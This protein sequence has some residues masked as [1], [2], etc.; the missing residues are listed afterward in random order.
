MRR[1]VIG[2]VTVL[3]LLFAAAD[4]AAGQSG[5]ELFGSRCASCH[6]ADGAGTAN[7][8]KTFNG[9][10]DLRT[11]IRSKSDSQL[12]DTIARGTEHKKYPHVFLQTGMT[13]GQV[14]EIVVYLRKLPKK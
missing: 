10:P 7:A 8:N 13:Q 9:M 14:S 5:A 3:F 1:N 4:S 2:V 12:F 11:A 6:G